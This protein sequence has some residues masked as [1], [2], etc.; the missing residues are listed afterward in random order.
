M[1]HQAK[2]PSEITNA[3][4]TTPPKPKLPLHQHYGPHGQRKELSHGLWQQIERY[5]Q[6]MEKEEKH[7]GKATEAHMQK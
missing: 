2:P 5:E 6:H 1:A 7:Q 4:A 3:A